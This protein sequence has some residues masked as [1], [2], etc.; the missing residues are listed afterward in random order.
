[1]C[2][3][4]AAFFNAALGI[5]WLPQTFLVP[6]RHPNLSVDEPKPAMEWAKKP[7]ERLLE[8]NPELQLHHMFDPNQDRLML[9]KMTYF[10]VKLLRLTQT[11]KKFIEQTL[12]PG[13]TI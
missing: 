8:A 4:T 13:G 5:P 1:V 6:V 12:E 10:R 7:A 3:S 11:Y 2:N 9:H